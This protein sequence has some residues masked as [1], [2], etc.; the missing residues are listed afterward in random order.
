YTNASQ[1]KDSGDVIGE[2]VME[3]NRNRSI[4]EYYEE[5]RYQNTS[6]SVFLKDI[7]VNYTIN[8]NH[9]TFGAFID[10]NSTFTDNFTRVNPRIDPQCSVSGP[11]NTSTVNGFTVKS[12][13]YDSNGN[14]RP[15]TFN[16]VIPRFSEWFARF[17]GET[18]VPPEKKPVLEIGETG[19]DP[20]LDCS[21][22]TCTSK[23]AGRLDRRIPEDAICVR[24]QV[25][26][27]PTGARFADILGEKG[28]GG[29]FLIGGENDGLR[30]AVDAFQ[31]V[32]A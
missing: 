19:C 29:V 8:D 6:G 27:A 25:R 17:G 1:W 12:C 24:N 3:K 9:T 31:A 4:D 28:A 14:D 16:L 20:D 23:E 2:L 7:H 13:A 32:P 5:V 22:G 18:G 10:L 30:F 15:D 21:G 11:F 26:E